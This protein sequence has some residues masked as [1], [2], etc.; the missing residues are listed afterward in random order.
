MRSRFLLAGV[1]VAALVLRLH[2]LT[3]RSLWYD[4]ASSWQTAK[5]P[6]SEL[7]ESV[8]LNVHLPL[9]YVWL[10]GWMRLFGESPAALR[11]YS[12]A[13]GLLTVVG[14]DRFGRELLRVSSARA[15]PDDPAEPRRFG[16]LLGALV[17]AS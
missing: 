7:M 4:E 11:G 3:D 16:L 10:K 1:V 12:I 8:R 15:T 6:L 14:M 17:A 13:F 5:L 2:H 9:Y